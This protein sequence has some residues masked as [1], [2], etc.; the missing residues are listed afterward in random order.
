MPPLSPPNPNSE[1]CAY[2]GVISI[3]PPVR[4][5]RVGLTTKGRICARNRRGL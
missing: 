4:L 5:K 2:A 3:A 1:P